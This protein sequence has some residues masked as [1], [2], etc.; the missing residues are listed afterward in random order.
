[1]P[2]GSVLGPM[3]FVLYTADLLSLIE[4]HGFNQHLFAD[5]TQILG[6][7]LPCASQDLLSACINEVAAWMHFNRLQL[8]T[9]KTEFLWSTTSRRLHQLPQLPLRV[10]SD[11]IA[12]ASI[13]QNLGILT[14]MSR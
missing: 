10:G 7:C 2:Q 8:N 6:C 11:R 13:V 5:D 12:P 3:L 4:S 1:M 14:M 9:A